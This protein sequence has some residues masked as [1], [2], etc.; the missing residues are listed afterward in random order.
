MCVKN[1]FHATIRRYARSINKCL[2][3][4]AY[5]NEVGKAPS[6]ITGKDL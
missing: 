2:K 1:Y 3:N 4:E 6:E 5:K